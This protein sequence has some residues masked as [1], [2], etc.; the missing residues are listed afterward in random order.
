MFSATKKASLLNIESMKIKLI[1]LK[2]KYVPFI[3][4]VHACLMTGLW[5]YVRDSNMKRE[6]F[7]N[8]VNLINQFCHPQLST[9]S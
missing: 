2:K 4:N 1:Q 5:Y 7:I 3:L 8:D 6:E 9:S